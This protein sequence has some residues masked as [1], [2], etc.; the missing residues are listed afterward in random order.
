MALSIVLTVVARIVTI[1]TLP[2]FADLALDLGEPQADGSRVEVPV[3]DA[4][5]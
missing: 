1:V 2:L 4:P 5:S 3:A